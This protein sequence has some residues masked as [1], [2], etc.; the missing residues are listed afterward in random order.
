MQTSKMQTRLIKVLGDP[1]RKGSSTAQT[2]YSDLSEKLLAKE[3]QNNNFHK[4]EVNL[5]LLASTPPRE[6]AD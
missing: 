4:G 5:N 6:N 3:W 2:L 1:T